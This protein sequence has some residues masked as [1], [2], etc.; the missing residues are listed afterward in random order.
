[1]TIDPQLAG[2]IE[3]LDQ[4]WPEPPQTLGVAGWRR[5]VE[6]LAR[7]ARRP[8]PAGLDVAD[9]EISANGREVAFR[10]FR[11]DVPGPLPV[12]IYMHGG[13]WTIGSIDSHDPITSDIAMETPCSV[14]SVNYALAPENPYPAPLEDCIAVVEWLFANLDGFDGGAG[15]IF[16]GGDSAGGNLAAALTL[17]YR[18]RADRPIA[19]QALFYPVTDSN[20][21]TPSYI[22]EANAPFLTAEQMTLFWDHYC[23][24]AEQRADPLAAPLKAGDHAAL[25]P[26]FVAVAEHDP[27]RDDG[28]AYARKLIAAAVPVDFHPG[29]GLIHGYLRAR[30]VCDTAERVYQA[31]YSWMRR[32][33]AAR[34][35]KPSA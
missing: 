13:G 35:A 34:L 31:F 17:N 23:P 9:R 2:F 6:E 22:S 4:A 26:A 19:G 25:P 10:I 33:S 21:E 20:L 28:T 18:G 1:M 15:G 16:V 14:V 3:A 11:P 29:K 12:L 30:A 24:R 8:R 5:R 27:L 7:N 32:E